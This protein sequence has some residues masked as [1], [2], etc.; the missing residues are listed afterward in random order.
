[1]NNP[2]V[3]SQVVDGL[4]LQAA[5]CAVQQLTVPEFVDLPCEV[6]DA[7]YTGYF[8]QLFR[9]GFMPEAA[10][11]VLESYEAFLDSFQSS[12]YEEELAELESGNWFE[13]LRTKAKEALC[14]LGENLEDP[15]LN[16]TTFIQ[17]KARDSE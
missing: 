13:Q 7:V 9:D 1:M 12:S 14:A 4:R 6:L 5:P 16:A 17:G 10:R 15:S 8:S 11:P 2:F 3:Y